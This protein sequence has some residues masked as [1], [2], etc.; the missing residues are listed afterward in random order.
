MARAGRVRSVSL[1]AVVALTGACAAQSTA[2]G[3]DDDRPGVVASMSIIA[4]FA[5]QVGGERV[6]VRSLVPV[7]AD[8]HVH[9]PRPS[10]AR[11]VAGADLV[12]GNGVGL[13]PWFDQLLDPAG[14]DAVRVTEELAHLVVD[15]EEGQPD[16]HLWMVPTM[17]AAYAERIAEAL[18]EL[19][20]DHAEAYAANAA[21][22]AEQLAALDAE[23]AD[24]LEAVPPERRTLVTSHDAY[25]YFADHYGFEVESVVGVTTDEQPSA[26]RVQQLVDRIREQDVPTI[27]VETTVN[28]AV[29]ERIAGDAGVEVGRPLYGDSVGEPGSGADDY[30]GMMRHNVAAIVDGLGESP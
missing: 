18:G 27:F 12:L 29:I 23:L 4:D 28:P 24:A 9:E 26:A 21:A 22:Y 7:G 19:D 2:G 14:R 25:S 6:T 15:D 8:P 10:D 13:E 16:P 30:V 3:E 20:P 11:A 17:A 1:L 5:E